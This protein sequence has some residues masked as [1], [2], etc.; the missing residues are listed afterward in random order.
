MPARN[1]DAPHLAAWLSL[2]AYYAPAWKTGSYPSTTD[3]IWLWSRPHPKAANP[4][5]PTNAR[6][7]NWDYTDD[8]LYVVVTLS[9]AAN[10]NIR[11]GSNSA[12]WSL[13]SG[14]SKLSLASSAGT[15][16]ATI[17]RGSTTVKNY[18]STGTFT[19]VS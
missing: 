3:Q 17:T 2:I 7:T 4:T 15:I 5:N 12:T 16:G 18:D 14:L 9:S 19:Y 11:S 6:P 10:V 13:P 1:A 8:N